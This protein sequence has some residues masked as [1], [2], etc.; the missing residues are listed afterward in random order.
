MYFMSYVG[1]YPWLQAVLNSQ[2][3]FPLDMHCPGQGVLVP[4]P[5]CPGPVQHRLGAPDLLRLLLL[6]YGCVGERF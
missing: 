6:E 4:S 1:G 3:I 5:H 2:V